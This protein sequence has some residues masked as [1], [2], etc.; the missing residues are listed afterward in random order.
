MRLGAGSDVRVGSWND[1]VIAAHYPL[2][3]GALQ[4]SGTQNNIKMSLSLW[5][6][7]HFDAHINVRVL[8]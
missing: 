3:I 7:R 2:A 6:R 8:I 1:D 5:Y 4:N